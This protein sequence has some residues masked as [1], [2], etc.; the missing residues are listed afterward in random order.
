VNTQ[1]GEIISSG[2]STTG[3]SDRDFIGEYIVEVMAYFAQP[4]FN[5]V[6]PTR[7]EWAIAHKKG[8][9]DEMKEEYTKGTVRS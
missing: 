8:E 1:T 6:F 3:L 9:W 2:A 5:C 4:P 7:E